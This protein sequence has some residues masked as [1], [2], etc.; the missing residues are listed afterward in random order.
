MLLLLVLLGVATLASANKLMGPCRHDIESV[1]NFK[2]KDV[3]TT[4]SFHNCTLTS[5]HN[6]A[7]ANLVYG[8]VRPI[9]NYIK[10][11]KSKLVYF[12]CTS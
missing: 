9:T 4:D 11:I 8:A 7:R 6:F 5:Y 10:T 3:S 1:H 12:S 2:Y